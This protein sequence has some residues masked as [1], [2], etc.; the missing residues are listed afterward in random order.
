MEALQGMTPS[1]QQQFMQYLE[2]QQRKDSLAMYN[3]L[4]FKCFDDCSRSFRSR[5]L[6]DSEAKCIGVCAEKFIKLTGRVARRF[7]DL[8]QQKAKE[9]QA[10]ATAAGLQR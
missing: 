6:D 4:V 2:T 9:E 1:Q 10:A 8:Q 5:R 7:Q 3:N